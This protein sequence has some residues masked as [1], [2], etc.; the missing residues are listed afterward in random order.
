MILSL[1]MNSAMRGLKKTRQV[2]GEMIIPLCAR[3]S[4]PVHIMS[5]PSP[6][7]AWPRPDDSDRKS[8]GCGPPVRALRRSPSASAQGHAAPDGFKD[9]R[10]SDAHDP[11]ILFVAGDQLRCFFVQLGAIRVG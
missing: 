10:D 7:A 4:S 5:T 8:P 2:R 11:V 3:K 1:E 6:P 9:R